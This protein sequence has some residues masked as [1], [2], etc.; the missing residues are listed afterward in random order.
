M[1]SPEN[2]RSKD[3]TTDRHGMS[4]IIAVVINMF[5]LLDFLIGEDIIRNP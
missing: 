5:R 4:L 3:F 1:G 2:D